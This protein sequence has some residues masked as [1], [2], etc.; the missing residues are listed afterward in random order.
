[1]PLKEPSRL[2]TSYNAL[3]GTNFTHLTPAQ[4]PVPNLSGK[5]IIITG[6]NNGIGLE[7]AKAFAKAGANLILGCREPPAWETHPTA[8]VAACQELARDAGHDSV[9]EWWEINMADL[10][11]VEAFAARWNHTGRGLD[12]LCNN[13]GMGPPMSVQPTL[14]K[15]GFEILHQV[16]F[17]SH[18]LLTLRLL[19][20]LAKSPSPRIVCTTSCFHFLGKFD[21]AHFNFEVGKIGSSYG[22][23]KLYFQIWVAELHRRLVAKE[24]YRHITVNGI[25]PGYVNTGIWT[26]PLPEIAFTI[27]Y[28]FFR[29]LATFFAINAQQGSLS[30]VYGAT[31]AEFGPDPGVQGVGEVGGRGGGH[32]INRI[33]EAE[34]MPHCADEETRLALWE[35]VSGELKLGERGLDA[36]L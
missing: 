27:G 15:D 35:K 24:K 11:S 32:Y 14:T 4:V 6:S 2:W 12:I 31:S 16:N 13:A 26:N 28:P 5:W 8:A 1:M 7:A 29:A 30:I 3:R 18:V 23:N 36:I 20:S 22:N 19:D 34:A 21:L 10:S 33:W 25:N 9:I 17:T